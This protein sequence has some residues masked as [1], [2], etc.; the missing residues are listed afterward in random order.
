[1]KK[2]LLSA[3]LTFGLLNA[4]MAQEQFPKDTLTII[5]PYAPGGSSD[6]LARALAQAISDEYEFPVIVDNRPGGG[7]VIGAQRLLSQKPDGHTVFI[8]A[9]SFVINSLLMPDLP[10][11]VEQDFQP[12]SLLAV[13]P[14][15]LVVNA[16]VP[17]DDVESFVSWAQQADGTYSSFGIGSSGHLGFELLKEATDIDMLHVPYKGSAPATLA[18][19][20]GEVDATLGDVGV[21]APHLSEGKIKPIAITGAERLPML[22][23]V[24]TFKEAGYPEFSSQTWLGLLTRAEVPE[25]R[26][27]RLNEIFNQALNS[28]EVQNVLALQGMNT[29]IMSPIEFRNYMQRE[30]EKYKNIINS[31]EISLE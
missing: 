30:K 27:E 9:A 4:P 31:A 20:T 19:L 28:K 21:V 29:Q 18:V 24:P 22:P 14:H 13:N 25:E 11:D 2:I 17:A 7:T 16:D 6:S 23:D 15:L 12:V 1:M 10:F 3:L 5:V 26:V 8:T